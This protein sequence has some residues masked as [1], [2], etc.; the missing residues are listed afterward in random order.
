M[1]HSDDSVISVAPPV[2]VQNGEGG[3]KGMASEW[4]ELEKLSKDELIIELVHW[5][6]LYGMLRE[7]QDETCPLPYAES[8]DAA[9]DDPDDYQPGEYTTDEWAEKIA[10]YGVKHPLDG[11]F[12][13]CDL[14]YYGLTEVQADEVCRRLY[15]E[16]RLTAPEGVELMEVD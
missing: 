16:G 6:T 12:Y 10:L 3:E 5:K 8:K 11:A 7:K 14:I 13:S 9:E 15:K 2:S 4:E 1:P